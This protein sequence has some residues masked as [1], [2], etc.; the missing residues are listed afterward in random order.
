MQPKQINREGNKTSVRVIINFM[1]VSTAL[2]CGCGQS[3]SPYTHPSGPDEPTS[4]QK[5]SES[6]PGPSA[7]EIPDEP[8]DLRQAIEIA[9]ANNPEVAAVGWDYRAAKARKE[10]ASAE[11]LPRFSVAGDYTRHLDEQR[12]LPVRQPGDPAILSRDIVSGDIVLTMP[13]Y[14]WGRLVNQIEAAEL[15]QEAAGHRLARSRQELI[16]NVSSI[17]FG[18]LAQ[19]RV[20]ESLEFSEQTLQ[21]HVGRVNALIA[22]QKASRVDRLRTEVRLADLQQRLVQE[23]NVMT[24]QRR[25]MASLLGS[26]ERRE[27]IAVQGDLALEPE[28]PVPDFEKALEAAWSNRDDYLAA[29]SALEAQA[30]KMD[31]ARAGYSP[32]ISLQGS[33]GGRWATGSTIGTGDELDDLGRIGVGLGMLFFDGGQVNAQVREQH[34]N[35]IA[36]RERLRK[37]ELQVR[38]EIETALLNID[39]SR[40]RVKAI[41]TSIEQAR[42]SL[43]IEQ[44][45]YDLGKGAIVDVLDAQTALLDAQTNYSRA[46]ADHHVAL[47]QLKLA[48][49]KS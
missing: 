5:L 16:F 44:E 27:A 32:V 31:A 25:V 34:A 47:A 21:E 49:G 18:I 14:T 12:P 7:A 19:R 39:S 48:M 3:Y 28:A 13:I 9:L 4:R 37:L 8:L 23:N 10:Q 45:K 29:K 6:S 11:R 17:F 26:A 1:A 33:Y 36:A 40:E 2:I 35:L 43:R 41:Q 30:R 20:I 24:I 15:L 46:L 42:E 22:A 38:L